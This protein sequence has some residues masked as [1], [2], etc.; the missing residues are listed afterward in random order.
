MSKSSSF[1]RPERPP[2]PYPGVISNCLPTFNAAWAAP[3]FIGL[4][5][6]RKKPHPPT[7]PAVPGKT[8]P[9]ASRSRPRL[10]VGEKPP[11]PLRLQDVLVEVVLQQ[12][13]G[14]PSVHPCPASSP[15]EK[16]TERAG[17]PGIDRPKLS[18]FGLHECQLYSCREHA[19]GATA[20]TGRSIQRDSGGL[21]PPTPPRLPVQY[22]RAS[23][24]NR[25]VH[26][27]DAT[28]SQ[29]A[30]RAA[31]AVQSKLK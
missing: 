19:T 2:R 11:R 4:D 26:L 10:A 21:L 15:V 23:T 7:F 29:A 13:P 5:F 14:L 22:R 20:A 8:R 16:P 30:E 9:A 6:G 25:Y 1:R 12:H 28:L 24:T 17:S 27:D 3:V 31:M 18:D